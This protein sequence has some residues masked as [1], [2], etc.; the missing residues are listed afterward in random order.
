MRLGVTLMV[1]LC[2]QGLFPQAGFFAADAWA[3]PLPKSMQWKLEQK[4]K[5]AA[6]PQAR[7]GNSITVRKGDTVY[8]I[9]KTY[10]VTTRDI[11]TLNKLRPPYNLSIGQR[12]KMPS[13]NYYKVAKGDTLYSISR[14]SGI[15]MHQLASMNGLSKPYT[16]EVGQQLRLPTKATRTQVASSSKQPTS[17]PKRRVRQIYGAGNRPL[18]KPSRLAVPRSYRAQTRVA[19]GPRIRKESRPVVAKKAIPDVKLKSPGYFVWPVRGQVISS[20]GPKK[21]G[22][23]NDGIN[24][25]SSHGKS[26]RAAADGVVVFTGDQLKGYGNLMIIRHGGGWLSAYAHQDRFTVARGD[27]VKRGQVIGYVGDTGKVKKP[28]LH[29][30]IRKGRKAVNPMKHLRG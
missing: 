4:K 6:K 13:R 10:G 1:V 9:A 28:Q 25:S 27:V 16:L 30:A 26:V 20:F 22:I 23:Y 19:S 11:I 3:A 18:L 14:K 7:A 24:I 29:F 15:D 21:G 5:A 2:L 12:L 17:T 8:R